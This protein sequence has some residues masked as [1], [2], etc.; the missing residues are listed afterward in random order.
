[1]L[2]STLAAL[3]PFLAVPAQAFFILNHP[4]LET[5]RLDP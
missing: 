1:M 2:L 4:V 3:L 5:T